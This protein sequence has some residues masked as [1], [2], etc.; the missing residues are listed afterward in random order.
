MPAINACDRIF[1][2]L[3]IPIK[4]DTFFLNTKMLKILI[5]FIN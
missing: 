2:E 5:I 4:S 1:P 3:F